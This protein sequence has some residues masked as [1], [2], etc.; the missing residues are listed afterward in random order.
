MQHLSF[1][2]GHLGVHFAFIF[3]TSNPHSSS[4]CCSPFGSPLSITIFCTLPCMWT[5]GLFCGIV[6]PCC[7]RCFPPSL[8]FISKALS[9]SGP[10]DW[11]ADDWSKTNR[12]WQFFKYVDHIAHLLEKLIH[13]PPCITFCTRVDYFTWNLYKCSTHIFKKELTI[14]PTDKVRNVKPMAMS[15]LLQN[16]LALGEP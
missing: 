5:R 15:F 8:L 16:G 1:S 14:F 11:W 3:F 2:D 10:K 13:I 6:V 4:V 7:L 9:A 12:A